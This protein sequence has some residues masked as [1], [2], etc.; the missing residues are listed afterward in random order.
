MASVAYSKS[1]NCVDRNGTNRFYEWLFCH[2]IYLHIHWDLPNLDHTFCLI[3]EVRFYMKQH[4]N[5]LFVTIPVIVFAAEITHSLS[6]CL[7][8]IVVVWSWFIRW[9]AWYYYSKLHRCLTELHGWTWHSCYLY[10]SQSRGSSTIFMT[11]SRTRS[12][13]LQVFGWARLKTSR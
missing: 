10:A 13:W 7:R 1:S 9:F 11:G 5:T 8:V 4:L 6:L 3:C 2:Q 12:R